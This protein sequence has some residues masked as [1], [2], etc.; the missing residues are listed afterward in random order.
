VEL[1]HTT[2]AVV[3]VSS[4][5]HN[6]T[7]KPEH[8]VDG[9]LDT[10]WNSR[11]G[12]LQGAWI[13]FRVPGG[14]RVHAIALTV[15][16]THIDGKDDWFTM[17]QRIQK[18]TVR[19][20]GAVVAE[21]AL[22]VDERGLQRVVL[23]QPGGDFEIEV[24]ALQPGTK[25]TWREVC[26]SELEVR[27]TPP[28]AGTHP[29]APPTVR[30]GSLDEAPPLARKSDVQ[31]YCDDFM[32][33]QH[34]ARKE[35]EAKTASDVR[36]Q[37]DAG[38]TQEEID[39]ELGGDDDTGTGDC[40]IES[41]F[42]EGPS[43]IEPRPPFVAVDLINQRWA[44]LSPR[45]VLV[46]ITTTAG[47]YFSDELPLNEEGYGAHP[48]SVEELAFRGTPPRLFF[49]YRIGRLD[50]ML[51]ELVVC[52]VKQSGEASCSGP[53]QVGLWATQDAKDPEWRLV[54]SLTPRGLHLDAVG[55]AP[56]GDR[57]VALAL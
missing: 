21:Q 22:N 25:K 57:D 45:S 51:E 23:D 11:T 5:V 33:E 16:Y 44:A 43:K 55:P 36:Q 47:T 4:V 27:G 40:S 41:P 38:K 52:G 32:A 6:A 39:Q 50:T 29:P 26:V 37:Q 14:A 9:K 3:A 7:D 10:A 42:P 28:P 31:A 56:P 49:R 30:V 1:L 35:D 48:I 2:D 54:P 13:R 19:R 17:N 8:L 15:G 24:T 53:L 12:D 20:A 34:K 46:A 18:I